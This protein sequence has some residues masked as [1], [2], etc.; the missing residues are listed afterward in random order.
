VLFAPV[1]FAASALAP[2]AV[3]VATPPAP[4]GAMNPATK[5]FEKTLLDI[6][7]Y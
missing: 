2:I 3:F 1:V 7:F 4:K 5:T 6:A